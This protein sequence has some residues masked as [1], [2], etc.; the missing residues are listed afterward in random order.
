MRQTIEDASGKNR[1]IAMLNDRT[2][3]ARE[4]L[5]SCIEVNTRQFAQN[6]MR[7][8]PGQGRAVL[9]WIVAASLAA[10]WGSETQA[11]SEARHARADALA[12]AQLAI[13]ASNVELGG[14][15]D[16]DSETVQA[17][18]FGEKSVLVAQATAAD[19]K[20]LQKALEQEH[21]RTEL[22][23]R[24]L[25]LH[26]ASVESAHL[27]QVP[28]SEYAELLESL[29]QV[30]GR[31][32]QT[33]DSGAAELCKSLQ[34][35][36]A[37]GVPEQDLEAARL[38]VEAQ[39]ALA[40]K[41][42]ADATQLGDATDLKEALQRERARAEHLE[43]DLVAARRDA[44][45]QTALAAKASEEAGELKQTAENDA[46]ELHKSLR[47]AREYA[48]QLEQDLAVARRGVKIQAAPAPQASDE[49][50]ELK[51]GA[52]N[53][54]AEL[55]P[56]PRKERDRTEA[57]AHD[58]SMMHSAIYAY[59]AQTRGAGH[60]AAGVKQAARSNAAA[61]RKSLVPEWERAARLQQALAATRRDVETQS[62]LAIRARAEAVRP[63]EA[64]EDGCVEFRGPL[65]QERDRSSCRVAIAAQVMPDKQVKPGEIRPAAKD[66]TIAEARGHASPDRKD[67]AAATK[68]VARAN[69]LLGQGDVGSARIVLERAAET[70]NAQASFRLAETYDP[71]ILAKWRTNGTRGDAT[72]ALGLYA[73][74][75]AGGIKEA[76]ERLDALRR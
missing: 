37:N 24:L 46:A 74:A 1:R 50:T 26:K 9:R 18:R 30:R 59:E 62:S 72:R 73:R 5:R 13:A 15:G 10:T 54:S 27:N 68:L 6:A 45:T 32:K 61:L 35:D 38:G 4:N 14:T 36:R 52:E 49:V 2:K 55:K 12:S 66:Q 29:Q 58:L 69:V 57:L 21:H 63:K 56:S 42:K 41:A 47:E 39:T 20:E 11:L 48:A 65:Q 34:G 76:T 7:R 31:L 22:I 8:R 60:L 40:A 75:Q 25:T 43:R 28:E 19:T 23:E 70:G 16:R 71:L 17:S 53:G 67:A 51:Q 44:V 3:N 64:A 33:S